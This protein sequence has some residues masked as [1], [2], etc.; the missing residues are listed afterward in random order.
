MFQNLIGMLGRHAID[1]D[2]E[3]GTG[4]QNLIGMLGRV[5]TV[6]VSEILYCVSKPYRYAR[7]FFLHIYIIFL[8][9]VSKPYRYARKPFF[10]EFTCNK[11]FC[12]KTL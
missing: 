12:F 6:S 3:A 1:V 4:F 9:I 2:W 5:P 7:K 11:D 10:V 8:Y